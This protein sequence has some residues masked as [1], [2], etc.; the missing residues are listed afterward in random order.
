[1][2]NPIE[3]IVGLGNPGPEY[4]LTRHNAGFWFVEALA[5]ACG[6]T[7]RSDRKLH[8]EATDVQL[9]SHRLRLLKPL[10]FMNLSGRAVAATAGFYKIPAERVLVVYDELD[11]P[12]GRVK[13]KFGGGAAGHRG[14]A[15]VIEHIGEGF[16]RLRLGI[17]HPG[18]GR[19]EEVVDYVLRRAPPAEQE[20]ML[21][22]ISAALETL[23][24][25]IEL[26]PE[27]AKNA[28]HAIRPPDSENGD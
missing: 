24:T 20:T 28:L 1:M 12:P 17:G 19:R 22:A 5:A 26:G 6:G 7:F 3:L 8:G 4:L 23:P 13:L 10:T 15:S 11:L 18:P 16:W 25:L 21:A 27:R 14:I 2:D 9:D